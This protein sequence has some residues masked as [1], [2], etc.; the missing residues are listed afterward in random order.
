MRRMWAKGQLNTEIKDVVGSGELPAVRADEIVEN[1]S[2]YSFLAG[3]T[4]GVTYDLQYAGVVKNGNKLTFV[5][6]GEL[7]RTAS[8][9][10]DSIGVGTFTIPLIIAN[11]LYPLRSSWL[12]MDNQYLASDYYAGTTLPALCFKDDDVKINFNMY[13]VNT[14]MTVNVKYAFRIEAT[15]LLSDNLIS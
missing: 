2:G 10:S 4:S 14:K 1:M 12:R 11:K 8:I 5:I 9:D 6:A 7:T 13:D 15:F 3:S